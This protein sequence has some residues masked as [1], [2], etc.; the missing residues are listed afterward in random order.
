MQ[1]LKMNLEFL[2]ENVNYPNLQHFLIRII[3]IHWQEILYLQLVMKRYLLVLKETQ[4]I[5]FS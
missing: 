5:D 1:N 2:M 3:L 4:I